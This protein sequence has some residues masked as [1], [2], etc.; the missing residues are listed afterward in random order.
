MWRVPKKRCC[1]AIALLAL[2]K[3]LLQR[4]SVSNEESLDGHDSIILGY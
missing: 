1:K 4:A 2:T 3:N